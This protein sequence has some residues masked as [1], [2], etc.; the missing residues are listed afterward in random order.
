MKAQVLKAEEYLFLK[1]EGIDIDACKIDF[2][3]LSV[4]CIDLSL[5]RKAF[6]VKIRALIKLGER[7]ALKEYINALYALAYFAKYLYGF[8]S[9]S[10]SV[11]D[12]QEERAVSLQA[13][14]DE[15]K[16]KI[17]T[18]KTWLTYT[19]TEYNPLDTSL[20]IHDE[21]PFLNLKDKAHFDA[22]LNIG[23]NNND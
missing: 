9:C 3:K 16:I 21:K 1:Q 4:S 5:Y 19:S 20:G 10:S 17:Y 2:K 23:E 22:C 15:N 14:F 12:W 7:E 8:H 18:G 11:Q 13:S 6:R